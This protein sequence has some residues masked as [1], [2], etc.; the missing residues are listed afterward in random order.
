ML[1]RIDIVYLY[2]FKRGA[3]HFFSSVV[4]AAFVQRARRAG[5]A[6]AAAVNE[7][8]AL[9]EER[10]E[11][12]RIDAALVA[13]PLVLPVLAADERVVRRRQNPSRPAAVAV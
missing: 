10:R 9:L 11:I 5:I 4:E 3:L 7:K 6:A 2:P 1:E 8:P 13:G 12:E